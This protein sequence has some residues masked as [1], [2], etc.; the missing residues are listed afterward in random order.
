[1]IDATLT[2][3]LSQIG[4]ESCTRMMQSRPVGAASQR[5]QNGKF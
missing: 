4:E 1:M 5:V 2:H 3:T